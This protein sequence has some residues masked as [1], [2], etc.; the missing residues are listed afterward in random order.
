MLKFIFII[1]L[2]FNSL[3]YSKDIKKV[4]FAD[5]EELTTEELGISIPYNVNLNLIGEFGIENES[6]TGGLTIVIGKFNSL[7]YES[8]N[9]VYKEKVNILVSIKTAE[10]S[11]TKYYVAYFIFDYLLEN[12][13]NIYS[14]DGYFIST[15]KDKNNNPIY[16]ALNKAIKCI[17]EKSKELNYLDIFGYG[18][19]SYSVRNN[20]IFRFSL[21][22]QTSKQIIELME[23]NFK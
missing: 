9:K 21:T 15:L 17:D 23:I 4:Y 12:K 1:I 20:E 18:L 7:I 16:Y 8:D 5:F 10:D 19:W 14:Y 3:I 2:V 13:L 6:L 11:G 22:E